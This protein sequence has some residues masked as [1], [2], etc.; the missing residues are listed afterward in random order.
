[1]NGE[2]KEIVEGDPETLL[3]EDVRD[4][5]TFGPLLVKDGKAIPVCPEQL[6]GLTTPR[7]ASK[8]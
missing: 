7:I 3:K 6:G 5:W 4:T 2:L 8:S 1:M